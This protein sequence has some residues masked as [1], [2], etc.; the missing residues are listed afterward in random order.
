MED[1]PGT[2]QPRAPETDPSSATD[3]SAKIEAEWFPP[4]EYAALDRDSACRDFR[5]RLLLIFSLGLVAFALTVWIL[6][7]V[8]PSFG[9][10]ASG[11]DEVARAQL[12]A[13]GRGDLRAAY[14]MF[15]VRYRQQV[16][17]DA[18]HELVIRHWRMFHAEVLG[19]SEPARSRGGITLVVHLR[20]SDDKAYR[21]RFTLIQFQG[22]WWVDDLHW[23]EE[24]D[25]HDLLKT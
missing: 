15:S 21:A 14:G 20:G 4:P 13:L 2:P 5:R 25:E 24:P 12:R 8:E 23:G 18:W 10:F 11:P 3:S 6:S 22:R 9:D 7:R 17:F 16:S 19:G 1:L